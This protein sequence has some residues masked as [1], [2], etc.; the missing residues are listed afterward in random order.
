MPVLALVPV[1]SEPRSSS[2]PGHHL[3]PFN[4]TQELFTNILMRKPANPYLSGSAKARSQ[5]RHFNN[6]QLTDGRY[7]MNQEHPKTADT[8]FPIF[9]AATRVK[10]QA[11]NEALPAVGKVKK[12]C[13][14]PNLLLPSGRSGVLRLWTW[15]TIKA[16]GD[17]QRQPLPL[18]LTL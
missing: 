17:P 2:P 8:N 9:D 10:V 5:I 12:C 7:N 14:H 13:L 3:S 6:H 15:Q 11:V 18:R 16:G 1:G 4:T